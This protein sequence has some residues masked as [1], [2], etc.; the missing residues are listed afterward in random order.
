MEGLTSLSPVKIKTKNPLTLRVQ[1]NFKKKK[2]NN[3]FYS[4]S[5]YNWTCMS[6]CMRE[7]PK[8]KFVRSIDRITNRLHSIK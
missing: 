7:N 4:H 1:K 3:I 5:A 2:N 8:G 6:W